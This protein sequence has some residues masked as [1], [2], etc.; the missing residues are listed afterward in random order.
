MYTYYSDSFKK[1]YVKNLHWKG[2]INVICMS[3]FFSV[4]PNIGFILYIYIYMSVIYLLKFILLLTQYL[5]LITLYLQDN[6]GNNS[7]IPDK[8][9]TEG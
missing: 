3:S 9:L 8:G 1:K 4:G 7:K 2:K 5:T 6:S